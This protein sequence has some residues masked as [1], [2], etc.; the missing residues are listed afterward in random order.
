VDA[1]GEMPDGTKFDGVAGLRNALLSQ[2]EIFLSALTEKLM[3]Y[4]LGRGLEAYDTPAVRAIVRDAAKGQYKFSSFI[5]G[6]V[7]SVPFRMRQS[8]P[9]K[10]VPAATSAHR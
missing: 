3:I 10:A 1:Q 6:I 4:G 5:L 7:N 8:D 9:L 2:P